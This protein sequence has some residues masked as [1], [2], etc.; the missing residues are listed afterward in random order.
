M[1]KDS[2]KTKAIVEAGLICSLIV[3][4]MMMTI[5]IPLF[6][7]VGVFILPIPITVLYIRHNIKITTTAVLVSA[8][9]I[10]ILYNPISAITVSI[11]MGSTG[12]ALGYCIINK[13]S[14]WQTIVILSIVSIISTVIDMSIYV[15]L[16]NKGGLMAYINQ[17]VQITRDSMN[18]VTEIYR[19]MGV[20]ETQLQQFNA[21]INIFTPEFVMQLIPPALLF[22][23]FASAYIN[24]SFTRGV[25]RRLGY[26][27]EPIGLFSNLYIN[28]RIG[29]LVLVFVIVGMLLDRNNILYGKYFAASAQI[30]LQLILLIDGIALAAYYLK[31]KLKL[32]KLIM[33]LLIFFT[34]TSA[35][36]SLSY[37]LAGLLDMIF[38]FRKLDP[39]RRKKAQ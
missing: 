8:I 22:M 7:I 27:I 13:K 30:V 37:I 1:Q 18:S 20:P 28:N 25:L 10:A 12:I 33:F 16:I 36:L 21:S 39:F 24:Y 4:L 38:D 2:Y 5:Y 14:V 32:N 6:S 19:G 17:Q 15:T 3:A 9:F 26:E 31:N 35:T 34:V 23:G 11:M 29:T